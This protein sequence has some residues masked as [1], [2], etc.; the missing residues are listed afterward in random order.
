MTQTSVLNNTY[1]HETVE[2]VR[3]DRVVVDGVEQT[4]FEWQLVAEYERPTVLG[5]ADVIDDDGPAFMLDG[6]KPRGV[7]VVFARVGTVVLEAG[8]IELT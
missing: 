4:D 2:P 6:T 7:Y 5:W 8:R 3:F 1:P